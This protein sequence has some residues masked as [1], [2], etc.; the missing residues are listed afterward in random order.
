[1]FCLGLF[2][3]GIAESGSAFCHWAY[4]EN[5][6]QKTKELAELLGCPTYYSKDTIKCLRSRPATAIVDSMKNFLVN[7][8]FSKLNDYTVN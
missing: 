4:A 7:I 2:N 5:V 1:M 3:R 6:V 8:L